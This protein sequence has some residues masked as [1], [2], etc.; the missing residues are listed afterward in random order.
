MNPSLWRSLSLCIWALASACL[1]TTPYGPT[2]YRCLTDANCP[3][4]TYCLRQRCE[5]KSPTPVKPTAQNT[6]VPP[7]TTL[8]L[9]G[10]PQITQDGQIVEGL[11]IQGCVSIQAN[12]VTFRRSRVRCSSYYVVMVENGF[13]NVVIEDVEIDGMG[14]TDGYGL[15]LHS[16]VGRRLRISNLGTAAV[17]HSGA[18]LEGSFVHGLVGSKQSGISSNG[19]EDIVVYGNNAD[20]SPST[21]G[22]AMDLTGGLSRLQRVRV[23]HNWVNGGHYLFRMG[24][25]TY[26]AEDVQVLRNRLGRDFTEMFFIGAGVLQT[27]NVFDDT[28]E[29]VLP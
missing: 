17:L 23:E 29:P 3:T 10:A 13:Q 18:R 4:G 27:E 25:G 21:V 12:N 7:D 20:L 14:H 22:A 15:V 9:S 24:N 28:G 5:L 1:D 6:G 11:D 19:G 26:G 2:G 8:T 16:G